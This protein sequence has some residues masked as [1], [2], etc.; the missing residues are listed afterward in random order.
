[1]A[2]RRIR[3]RRRVR[4]SRCGVEKVKGYRRH[5]CRNSKGQI[6]SSRTI[7]RRRKHGAKRRHHRKH[8]RHGGGIVCPKGSHKRRIKRAGMRCVKRTAR[9]GFRFV[10]AVSHGRRRRRR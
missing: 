7:R 2:K 4:G 1:M 8:R 9:G 10:K 6:T 5:V 3:R